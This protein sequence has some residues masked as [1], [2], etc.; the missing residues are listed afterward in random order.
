MKKKDANRGFRIVS[1]IFVVLLC[2]AVGF[3]LLMTVSV[4]LQTMNEVYSADLNTFPRSCSSK[5]TR[6]Q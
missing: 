3:P 6:P 2:L 4:S 5:T 1:L